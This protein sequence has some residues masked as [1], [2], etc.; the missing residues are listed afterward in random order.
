MVTD[1]FDKLF[2]QFEAKIFKAE[3]VDT[4]GGSLRIYVKK[5]KK[6]KIDKSITKMIKEEEK[7]GLKKYKT[8]Q[9]FGKQF[10]KFVNILQNL[11]KLKR[12]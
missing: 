6:V 3:V 10:I 7:F 2:N 1:L 9:N 4:H 8:Y 5:D 12:K 11:K